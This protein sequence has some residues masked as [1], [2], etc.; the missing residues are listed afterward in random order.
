MKLAVVTAADAIEQPAW[1]AIWT[2]SHFEQAVSDQLAVKGFEMFLPR[3]TTW[4][5]RAQKRHLVQTPLFP[6]YVFVRHHMDKTSHVE[7]LKARG[8]VRV[9]GDRW[10]RLTPV[11][12]DQI[13]AVRRIV[14][15]R[16]PAFPCSFL[17]S[18]AK[19]RVTEGPLEGLEGVLLRGRPERGLLVIS[20]TLLQR[21]VAVE[22][23]CTLVEA[24]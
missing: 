15:A 9:L 23:D 14:D 20:L 5:R 2:R 1:Y 4:T 18:G 16:A 6:G 19:V 13:E 11:P 7:V 21:A 8:V 12:D 10:D 3:T 22:V 17:Q 24:A